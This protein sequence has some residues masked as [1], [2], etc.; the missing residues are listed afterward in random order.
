[1]LNFVKRAVITAGVTMVAA[2][3]L[4]AVVAVESAL[5]ALVWIALVVAV[6][7]ITWKMTRGQTPAAQAAAPDVKSPG[8]KPEGSLAAADQSNKKPQIFTEDRKFFFC[9]CGGKVSI[10]AKTCP[11]CGDAKTKEKA[12][13]REYE[14]APAGAKVFANFAT[15]ALVFAVI[16]G[17]YWLFSDNG[18]GDAVAK[19]E[20]SGYFRMS[21]DAGG[22]VRILTFKFRPGTSSA[23]IRSHGAQQWV[24]QPGFTQAFY[25]PLNSPN[26]PEHEL[27]AVQDRGIDAG[28]RIIRY[29]DDWHYAFLHGL[30]DG[31]VFYD[32]TADPK[33]DLCPETFKTQ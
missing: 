10:D 25:Y 2:V 33:G 15:A 3:I 18:E 14:N 30:G 16:A 5:D 22:V 29:A 24:D 12:K 11:H 27:S 20:S 7:V 26:V 4:A 6:G 31:K 21:N 19:I 17:I 32:C 1:M 8:E 9:E 23:D 28:H 13:K